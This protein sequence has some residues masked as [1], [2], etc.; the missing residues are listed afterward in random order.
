MRELKKYTV[1]L[2]IWCY[3]EDE[4]NNIYDTIKN[5]GFTIES[6]EILKPIKGVIDK[7]AIHIRTTTETKKEIKKKLKTLKVITDKE[8]YF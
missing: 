2:G 5:E 3:S 7:W 1:G 4:C 6:I 8:R